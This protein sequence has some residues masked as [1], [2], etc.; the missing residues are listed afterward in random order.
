MQ[1][2][3]YDIFKQPNRFNGKKFTAQG[4]YLNISASA[5]YCVKSSQ[6]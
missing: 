1:I 4:A 2:I 6:V 5:L 3:Y